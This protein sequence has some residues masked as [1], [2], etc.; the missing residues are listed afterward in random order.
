M[1]LAGVPFASDAVMEEDLFQMMAGAKG[2]LDEAGCQLVG[3]H[4]SE[5]AELGLGARRSTL[6]WS[7]A[8]RRPRSYGPP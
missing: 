4:S 8:G 6:R 1:A 3:G 7:A 2:A 5:A